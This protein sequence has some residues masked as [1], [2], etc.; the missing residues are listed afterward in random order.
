MFLFTSSLNTSTSSEE[1]H[2]FQA[3]ARLSVRTDSD[4]NVL[5]TSLR[6]L[7]LFMAARKLNLSDGSSTVLYGHG[8]QMF[9]CFQSSLRPRASWCRF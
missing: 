4:R 9:S 1:I 8:A 5:S 2:H 3:V 6:E 7:L